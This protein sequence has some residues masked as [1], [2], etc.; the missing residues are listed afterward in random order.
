MEA[1]HE[2]IIGGI[3]ADAGVWKTIG[4]EKLKSDSVS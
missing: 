4:R 3:S 1:L 2:S